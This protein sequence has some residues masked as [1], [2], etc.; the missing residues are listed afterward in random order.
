MQ[1]ESDSN[2]E[3][4]HSLEEQLHEHKRT[5]KEA[6]Q[7]ILHIKEELQYAHDALHKHKLLMK[8]RIQDRDKEIERLRNQVA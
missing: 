1:Q 6:D 5:R 7:E 4:L 3:Q 8:S 2:V